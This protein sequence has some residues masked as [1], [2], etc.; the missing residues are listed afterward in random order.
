MHKIL[1]KINGLKD[2]DIVLKKYQEKIIHI[3]SIRVQM[4]QILT[5]PDLAPWFE[6]QN[7]NIFNEQAIA[8]ED[9]LPTN[10]LLS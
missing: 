4:M 7:T 2:L 10:N 8:R 6:A 5:H 3:E 1:S 9:I